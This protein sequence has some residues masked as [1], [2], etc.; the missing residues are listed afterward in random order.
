M[1][2]TERVLVRVVWRAGDA[3]PWR[4][5]RRRRRGSRRASCRERERGERDAPDVDARSVGRDGTPQTRAWVRTGVYMSSA[6]GRSCVLSVLVV[7]CVG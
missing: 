1:A 6:V 7:L 2:R 3:V 5:W 4:W